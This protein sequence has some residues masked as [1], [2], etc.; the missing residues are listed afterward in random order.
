MS[1]NTS[2]YI[3]TTI[4]GYLTSRI[5][6][7]LVTA[8]NQQVTRQWWDDHRDEF[9]FFISQFVV[10]ECSAGDPGAAR[11]R[12]NLIGDIPELDITDDAKALAKKLLADVPLPDNAEV[13]ALHVAVAT[14]HGIDYLLTW[15]CTHIA[16]AVLRHR[17]EAV[18][19]ANGF[20]PPTICTPQELR[21][22]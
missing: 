2:V 9:D 18:C 6:R 3:E 17:I 16:N 13:D 14:V 19:R 1:P 4:I 15:N 11:E 21:E 7:E 10:E 20:E 12:L 22:I 5:S 8:A